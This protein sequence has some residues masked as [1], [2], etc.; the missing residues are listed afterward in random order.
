MTT[1]P[2]LERVAKRRA[3]HAVQTVA[4]QAPRSIAIKPLIAC[5]TDPAM[6]Q[7][8]AEALLAW[9]DRDPNLVVPRPS[10]ATD[11]TM[12]AKEWPPQRVRAIRA[13]SGWEREE[14]SR[15]LRVTVATVT[16]WEQGATAPQRQFWDALGELERRSL[17]GE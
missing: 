3:L 11:A 14:L 15:A 13:R 10:T 9:L 8:H 5:D 17:G 1:V 16:R 6:Q 4:R 12:A 2:L 7:G